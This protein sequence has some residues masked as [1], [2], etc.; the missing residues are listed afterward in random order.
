MLLRGWH[1]TLFFTEVLEVRS[2]YRGRTTSASLVLKCATFESTVENL[3]VIF[4]N[5][6][7][8]GKE[9]P[10]L[11]SDDCESMR[12]IGLPFSKK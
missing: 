6:G 8:L 9:C 4:L 7:D 5:F 11:F 12:S 1:W 3:A 2:C 10:A